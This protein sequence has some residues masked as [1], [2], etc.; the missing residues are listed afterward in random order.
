MIKWFQN[1]IESSDWERHLDEDKPV[2][3]VF[4]W[5]AILFS[6]V[7]FGPTILQVLIY[8]PTK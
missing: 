2:L 1:Y 8:G 5:V 4:C 6:V 7:W 3:T